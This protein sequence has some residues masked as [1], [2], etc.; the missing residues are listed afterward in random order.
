MN[1]SQSYHEYDEEFEAVNFRM[2]A[3]EFDPESDRDPR[4]YEPKFQSV[5]HTKE[6][7]ILGPLAKLP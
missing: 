6:K 4:L 2:R 1:R 7:T 3:E 5:K